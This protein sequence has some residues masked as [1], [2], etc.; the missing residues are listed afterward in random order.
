MELLYSL[1]FLLVSYI[2][3]ESNGKAREY[4]SSDDDLI[5]YGEYLNGKRNGKGKEYEVGRVIFEGEYL[6]GKRNGKGKEYYS[7]GKLKFEGEYLN[8]QRSGKGKEYHN[9]DSSLVFEGEYLNGERL[10]GKGYDDKGNLVYDSKTSNA[11]VKEYSPAGTL[12]FEGERS[13]ER[14]VGK[15]C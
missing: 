4:S 11:L 13:E 6:N 1:P 15:E 5:F 12:M 8:G 14:R 7:N 3:Y 10:T 9:Y 2:I